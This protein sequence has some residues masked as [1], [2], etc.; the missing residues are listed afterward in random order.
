ML[1]PQLKFAPFRNEGLFTDHYLQDVLPQVASLWDVGDLE[2]VRQE[3]LTLWREQSGQVSHYSEAQLEDHF[4]KPVLTILGHVFEPQPL[5]GQHKPDYAFFADDATRVAALPANGGLEYW[6]KAL[7][8]GDAKSWERKLDKTSGSDAGWGLSN[9]SFQVGEY[10]LAR[11]DCKW[12][13]LTNGRQWRLYAGEPK[14]D[15]QRFYEVDLPALLQ[16]GDPADLAYFVL[17]FRRDAFVPDAS[18][19]FFL[20]RVRAE[21]D[22]AA[23]KLRENV[24]EG[25]YRALLAACRGFVEHGANESAGD[26]LEA[27]YDNAL[28]LL[29]RLLFVLYA[30]AAELLPLRENHQYHER[31]SL[32]AIKQDVASN[33]Q[34]FL[35]GVV[36]LWPKLKALFGVIDRGHAGLGVPAYN[37]GLF[38]P[39]KH[40]FLERY[41]LADQHVAQVT[42]LLARTPEGG[43]VDYRDLGVRHLGSIYEGLLEYKLAR[44]TEPMVVV[45]RDG[46]DKWVPVSAVGEM[47]PE[48]EH[49]DA[50]ELYLVTDKGERKATGSY[51]TPQFIVEYIVENTVGPLV[52]KCKAPED[53]LKL[54]VLDPAMGSGHFLVEVTDFL[55]R[56]LL[57]KGGHKGIALADDE[58]DLS[59]L[60]RLVVERCIYGV[61]LNPLA[62]ELAKLSLWLDTVAKGQPLSFLDHH[63]RC[64]N[65]LIGA[66]VADVPRMPPFFVRRGAVAD[67]LFDEAAFAEHAD[68]LVGGTER[69]LALPSTDR[70]AVQRK[71]QLLREMDEQHRRPYR[72]IADLW[73]SRHFGNEY[74]AHRYNSLVGL[75]QRNA[76]P[77][78][79]E[80]KTALARSRELA[81]QYRFFHWELEFPDVFFDE[82]GRTKPEAGFEAVVGN[83]PWERMKLQENEFF[84][85]RE[86]AI[87]LAPTA[88]KRKALVAKLPEANPALWA[89]YQQA[90]QQADLELAWTRNSGQYP[91]MGCGDTNL[92]A[93]MTE[94]G[95]SLL[96]PAGREGFVVPSGIATD[97]TTSGFFADLVETK[98]L[99][100]LLDFENREG[101]FADVHRAFKFSIIIFTGGEQRDQIACGFFLQNAGYLADP[102]RVFTI[103]PEDCALMNPNTRTCPVFRSRRDLE[104]TRAVYERVP[105]LVRETE[106]GDENPWGIRYMRMFDMTL[107]SELF[108]TVA[109]LEGEGFYPV[110]GTVYRKGSDCRVPLYEGKMVQMYDH[111]AASVKVNPENLHRPA[112]PEATTGEQHARPDYAVTPQFWVPAQEVTTKVGDANRWFVAFK[113]VTAPTNERTMIAAAVPWSGA[114]N[115]LPLLLG[116]SQPGTRTALL[117]ANLC[118]FAFDYVARQKVGGQHLNYFIVEQLPALPPERY[119][120]DFHGARLA[121]FIAQRVL[122]LSYTAH[123]LAGFAEDMGHV[124]DQGQAKP[125]FPWDE[126]RRLHLR[127]QLDALYFHLYGLT[128]EEADYVLGTFPIVQRHDQERY[129]R[130]RTKDLILHYYNAYAAGDMG[131]WVEG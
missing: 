64:G 79:H 19:Q 36:T 120:E 46:Q 17:F 80:E 12:G 108:T 44:A 65:S 85:L 14:P 122:E 28:V 106:H 91:F 30:E 117:L 2:A 72:E 42:D 57:E 101:L 31:Y 54:K 35:Q 105:A 38:D 50:G 119:D 52:D 53:I 86:P 26:D 81:E 114:G 76:P 34:V 23:N 129:G 13:L 109:E 43:F 69:M 115:N 103:R 100:T 95:R 73:C 63:L 51:Y 89:E 68:G 107:D 39:Q 121:D 61:D 84:A 4:I 55:A 123:D 37:G 128:R 60:K 48:Q 82:H 29:Y 70:E 33:P 92:Y 21:S 111:R 131:A 1:Q 126:E 66:R 99:Q 97:N 16:S 22:L 25:V 118:S 6:G 20:D 88:A 49:C 130:F 59:R 27:V 5:A 32:H 56:K 7:A 8:V 98:S 127:C 15:M 93:V 77:V 83:P 9:P 96:E 24:Q 47:R 18:G 62:V 10:Y 41:E 40:P 3:L 74:D 67:T 94:R 102:E 45:R 113:D 11:T 87:A 116:S 58:S 75:L 71:G 78:S 124:D 125:P 104:L 90:K 112:S 110:A